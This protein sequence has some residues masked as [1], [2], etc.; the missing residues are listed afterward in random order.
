[1]S[2]KP[3]TDVEQLARLFLD[4]TQREVEPQQ[5]SIG[6]S[7]MEV[8]EVNQAERTLTAVVSTPNPDRYEEIVE[9]KAFK[10]RLASFK[11]NPVFCA[12]HVYVGM[13]GE[14]T[15]IG[16][17]SDLDVTGEGLVGT[18]KFAATPL[19]EQYWTLFRDGHMKAFSVGWLTYAWEMKSYTVGDP[20]EKKNLR[21]FTDVELIEIS[22]V[23]I[24]ANRESLVRA[25]SA[26]A[27]DT[28]LEQ[29]G[30]V[31]VGEAADVAEFYKQLDQNVG[32]QVREAIARELSTDAGSRLCQLMEDVADVVIRRHQATNP[33]VQRNPSTT[34]EKQ[35]ADV[36]RGLA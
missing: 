5:K 23:A 24:P 10:K 22:A 25:A 16:H 13:S 26:F 19:A 33:P 34:E 28:S 9:P 20:P 11:A 4:A 35:I 21:T 8:R 30:S 17:W 36:L 1:M 6:S 2:K 14:P 12:G 15:V 27:H 18:A 31:I 29:R 3:H 7:R 32:K